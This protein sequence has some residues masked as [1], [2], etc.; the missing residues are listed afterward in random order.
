MSKNESLLSE[1]FEEWLV[2][3]Y[4]EQENPLDDDMPDGFNEWL[5]DLEP[6][7]WLVYGDL[8]ATEE[9]SRLLDRGGK[10]LET[11]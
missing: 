5:C 8:F 11:I 7:Q 2:D 6:D 3:R 9:K 4:I 1:T 10:R